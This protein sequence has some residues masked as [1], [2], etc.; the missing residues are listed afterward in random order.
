MQIENLLNTS[1]DGKDEIVNL[2]RMEEEVK[3]MFRCFLLFDLLLLLLRT[4]LLEH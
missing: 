2:G 3:L 1:V 4:G